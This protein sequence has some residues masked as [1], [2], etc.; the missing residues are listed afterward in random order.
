MIEGPATSLWNQ[1]PPNAPVLWKLTGRSWRNQRTA[2]VWLMKIRDLLLRV[3]FWAL[4]RE[5]T[6]HLLLAVSQTFVEN[7][8]RPYIPISRSA[9]GFNVGVRE[10]RRI[11]YFSG[12]EQE[13]L[14]EGRDS[15]PLP[16]VIGEP[17][18]H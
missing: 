6:L 15:L 8:V 13:T 18:L 12:S 17:S 3:P 9:D 4:W 5:R 2:M 16:K 14:F 1:Y 11:I 7:T 10:S